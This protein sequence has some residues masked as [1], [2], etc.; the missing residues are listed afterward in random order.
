MA[1]SLRFVLRHRPAADTTRVYLLNLLSKVMADHN[2]TAADSLNREALRLAQRLGHLSSEVNS[3]MRSADLAGVKKKFAMAETIY[4]K[5]LQRVEAKKDTVLLCT[6]QTGLVNLLQ[7]Q[8][9][10][11]DALALLAR[12]RKLVKALGNKRLL[13]GNLSET[14]DTYIARGNYAR[15]LDNELAALSVAEEIQDTLLT[16][17][18]NSSLGLLYTITKDF[19]RALDYQHKALDLARLFRNT[20]LVSI[21]LSRTG[22]TLLAQDKPQPAVDYFRQ[23]LAI[24][25]PFGSATMIATCEGDLADALERTGTYPEALMHSYRSWAYLKT[26]GS[27]SMKAWILALLSRTYLHTGRPDSAVLLGRQ[28]FQLARQVGHK[29]YGRDA[30]NVLAEAYARL[31]NYKKAYEYQG[32]YLAYRDS[33]LNEETT[34]RI[35]IL[36]NQSDMASKQA[37]IALL[38][39]NDQLKAIETKRQRLILWSLLAV[40]L[41]TLAL[42]VV[43]IRNNQH[44]QQQTDHLRALDELKTRFFS[45][46]TH[47]FRT[48]LSLIILPAEQLQQDITLP[49]PVRRS[50]TGI[51]RNARQLLRLINQLLDLSKLEA[52]SVVVT[53]VTGRPVE[54]IGQTVD[55][56]RSA[57]EEKGIRLEFSS[58]PSATDY[59]FDA[60]K[61]EKIV[62][63]LLSN[64]LKFTPPDGHIQVHARITD[65]EHLELQVVDTGIGIAA[66]KLPHIFDRFYQADDTRTRSYEGSGIGLALVKELTQLLGGE[67]TVASEPGRGTRFDLCLPIQP[68]GSDN[69]LPAPV[70]PVDNGWDHPTEIPEASATGMPVT[71]KPVVLVVEDNPELRMLLAQGLTALYRVLTAP[72][73]REGWQRAQL[74]LPDIILS[75][76]M[77]PDM[78]GY[79]LCR[80][81]KTAPETSHIAVILLTA[82]AAPESRL[83]GLL[84]GADDYLAKPFHF[85]ELQLRIRNIL[86][87]RQK[88][89]DYFSL[90]LPVVEADGFPEPDEDPFLNKLYTIINE[91][92][93]SSGFGVEELAAAGGISRR[94][95]NRKLTMLAGMSANDFIR[96]YRLKRA[97]EL[98]RSGCAV[99]DTAYRVG[100]DNPS[101]FTSVFKDVY[102]KTPSDYCNQLS[103]GG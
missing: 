23:A 80:L 45:N 73:G 1:D 86:D 22:E 29:E 27:Q 38:Q 13:I 102:K 100:F 35:A 91:N 36:N 46:I 14:A 42:V 103:Q 52:G 88:L 94:T 44:K 25:R 83:E 101:Y 7:S 74:D 32:H 71:G 18:A 49:E 12:Q 92:L 3:L 63:N 57:A 69:G 51:H 99:A 66:D 77:M 54:F 40:V 5:T 62:Y 8:D 90:P 89:R 76:V 15:A 39:K 37:Q 30:A 59:L 64:A 78:D 58:E 87:R 56:F 4:R 17:Q 93:D 68:A 16:I 19:G 24:A 96:R 20:Y 11:D 31:N 53:Q 6:I 9:R 75:D 48:P 2:L 10:Y 61:W 81:V 98:L 95:L 21:A 28:S 67:I 97:A 84:Q 82:R 85:A 50:L 60:D 72:N 33:L 26:T 70:M 79:E 55:L 34:R 43:L 41:L 47:E 65:P